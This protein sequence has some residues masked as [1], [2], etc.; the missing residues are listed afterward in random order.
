MRYLTVASG[1]I[2]IIALGSTVM[3]LRIQSQRD[4]EN[5]RKHALAADLRH[6]LEKLESQLAQ[7]DERAENTPKV[8]GFLLDDCNSLKS[9]VALVNRDKVEIDPSTKQF[10]RVDTGNGFL[11][12]SCQDIQPALDGQKLTLS[13]GNPFNGKFMGFKINVEWGPRY[14]GEPGDIERYV[15]WHHDLKSKEYSFADTL[16]AGT[17]NK[18]YL[19]LPQTPA[20]NASYLRISV[21]T[22][23]VGLLTSLKDK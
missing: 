12:V 1:L 8:V 4:D 17:W 22:P 18:V 23:T 11:L 6:D 19:V 15:R 9:Q 13:I 16:E 3:T 14:L 5:A 21:A 10:V 2:A 20:E 7:Q